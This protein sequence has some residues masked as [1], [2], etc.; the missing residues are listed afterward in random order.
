MLH[1][2]Q[3]GDEDTSTGSADRV[4]QSDRAAVD[5]QLVLIEA[6]SLADCDGLCCECLVGLDQ[7]QRSDRS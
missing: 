5:V 2:V 4:A 7:I 6:Q 1:S 3:Q